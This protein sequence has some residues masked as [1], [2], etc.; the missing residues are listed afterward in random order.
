MPFGGQDGLASIQVTNPVNGAF[1]QMIGALA[2]GAATSD[3]LLMLQG[4]EPSTPVGSQAA[5]ALRVRAVAADGVTPVSGATIAWSATNGLQFSVCGGAS[6]CSVLS[7]QAGESS[8]WVTPTVTGAS[9]VTIAL[10]PLSYQPPQVQ[11]ATVVGTSTALDLA[12]VTPNYWIGQ[13]ATLAV[14][15]TVEALDLGVPLANVTVN[16]VITR[17]TATLSAGSATTDG[18]GFATVTANV[19]NLSSNVQVSACVSPNNSP[20]QSFALFATPVSAWTLETVSGSTQ[21]MPVGQ[22]FQ[23]LVMRVTDGSAADNPVLGT[24]VSFATT[25]TQLDSEPGGVPVLLGSSAAQVVSAQ[26]GMVSIVPS[27]QNVGPCAVFIT[28]SAGASNVQLQMESVPAITPTQPDR[29]Y[30]KPPPASR[31]SVNSN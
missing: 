20:C 13:G 21:V 29:A 2:Y 18:Q 24:S 7:D 23:P 30:S 11:Q 19:T 3:L 15:L 22:A 28:V 6:S 1:S 17:G 9:T 16:F 14:P 4:A 27:T 12:A 26:N 25:L 31:G 8:T 5:N 10:A